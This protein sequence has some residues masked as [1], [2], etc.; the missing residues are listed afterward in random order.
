MEEN[1]DNSFYNKND[2]NSIDFEQ[3]KYVNLDSK[4]KV[5]L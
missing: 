3:I 1:F 4:N 2:T 5:C